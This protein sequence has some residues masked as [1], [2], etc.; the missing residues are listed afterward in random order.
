M[1]EALKL[2]CYPSFLGKIPLVTAHQSPK[3]SDGS[4]WGTERGLHLCVLRIEGRRGPRGDVEMGVSYLCWFLT[5]SYSPLNIWNRHCSYFTESK[6]KLS[7]V[8]WLNQGHKA[9]HW[10]DQPPL[11]KALE[12]WSCVW[13]CIGDVVA[14]NSSAS[15]SQSS[16][17][18]SFQPLGGLRILW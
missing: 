13:L 6:V 9:A 10:L 1:S 7:K 18:A 8:K 4:H 12:S 11:P 14:G 17:W 15:K 3:R 2:F 5:S 16:W